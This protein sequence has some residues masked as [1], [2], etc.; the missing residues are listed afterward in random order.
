MRASEPW[1]GIGCQ[2]PFL[3]ERGSEY[4]TA[5]LQHRVE[6][7]R[8]LSG[9]TATC[10]VTDGGLLIEIALTMFKGSFR[11]P[12]LMSQMALST[13]AGSS[14]GLNLGR[15]EHSSQGGPRVGLQMSMAIP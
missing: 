8:A 4:A 13:S 1:Y 2:E 9:H 11:I 10:S 7:S 15:H 5:W 3:Q 12:V 6:K 14:L